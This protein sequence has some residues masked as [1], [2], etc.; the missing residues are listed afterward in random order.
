M[1]DLLTGERLTFDEVWPRCR[2]FFD[3]ADVNNGY[4]CT[5]PEQEEV[6]DDLG[7]CHSYSCPL[8]PF[9]D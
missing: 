1:I 4:G 2:Y 7:R 8:A 6:E 9:D 3:G 5:H